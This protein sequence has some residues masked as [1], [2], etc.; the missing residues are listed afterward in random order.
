MEET[1]RFDE[2]GN[3]QGL[4]ID[5]FDDYYITRKLF[6]INDM[7]VYFSYFYINGLIFQEGF[8]HRL[9]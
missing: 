5:Y 2:F 1:I 6:Y 3:L 7:V 9:F 8:N 4:W